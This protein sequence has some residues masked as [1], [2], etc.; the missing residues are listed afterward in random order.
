MKEILM[1]GGNATIIGH[2]FEQ[3]GLK[4]KKV[5]IGKNVIIGLNAVIFPGVEIG[6]EA[7]IAAGAI[8]PKDSRIADNAIFLGN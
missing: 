3:G 7:V 5:H 1:I 2:V 4:L 6:D 8:V